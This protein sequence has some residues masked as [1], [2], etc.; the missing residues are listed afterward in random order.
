[1]RK[2]L[3]IQTRLDTRQCSH[4]RLGRSSSAKTAWNSETWPTFRP[5]DTASSRVA[6]PRLKSYSP[7][8]V[9]NG[10]QYIIDF[11]SVKKF[12][13]IWIFQEVTIDLRKNSAVMQTSNSG[14]LIKIFINIQNGQRFCQNWKIW[15]FLFHLR[16]ASGFQLNIFWNGKHIIATS[17]KKPYEISDFAPKNPLFSMICWS[18]PFHDQKLKFCLTKP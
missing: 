10:R 1:M 11:S 5:T 3:R 16:P 4:G 15:L 2:P 12:Q 14:K 17:F 9:S 18:S 6:C 13:K 8:K 7:G